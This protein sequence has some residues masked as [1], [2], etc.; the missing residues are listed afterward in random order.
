M[1]LTGPVFCK[2]ENLAVKVG[3]PDFDPLGVDPS[4]FFHYFASL[5]Y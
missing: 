5:V 4:Y 1:E 2:L 3:N